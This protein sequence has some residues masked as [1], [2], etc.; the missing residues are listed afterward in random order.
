MEEKK[1]EERIRLMREHGWEGLAELSPLHDSPDHK[2]PHRDLIKFD[3]YGRPCG[4]I[5]GF[6]EQSFDRAIDQMNHPRKYGI[7]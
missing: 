7:Y 4:R 5:D 2:Y 3:K 6:V 1:L